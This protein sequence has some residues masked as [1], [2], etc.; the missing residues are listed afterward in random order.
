MKFAKILLLAPLALLACDPEPSNPADPAWDESER[1]S[2]VGCNAYGVCVGC[3]VNLWPPRALCFASTLGG[4]C[5]V[6]CSLNGGCG[7]QCGSAGSA[8]G[9]P[10]RAPKIPIGPAPSPGPK[11]AEW[12]DADETVC[13]GCRVFSLAP[14]DAACVV[15]TADV[16][17]AVGCSLA[18][19]CN[20][21]CVGRE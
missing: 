6:G 17:C 7:A 16:G 5:A 20:A 14:P 1:A 9:A 8:D 13:A 18:K 3:N 12:C 4:T 19:G 21:T 10:V 2:H 11:V 15:F